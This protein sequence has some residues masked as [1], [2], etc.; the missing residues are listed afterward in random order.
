MNDFKFK[1]LRSSEV[2]QQTEQDIMNCFN[3]TFDQKKQF[4]F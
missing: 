2:D 4:I 3:K 1:I